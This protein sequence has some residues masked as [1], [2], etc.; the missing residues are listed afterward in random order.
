MFKAQ[1][2]RLLSFLRDL[3]LAT[4]WCA[5]PLALVRYGLRPLLD[6]G[7]VEHPVLA[8][9][10]GRALISAALIAGYFGFCRWSERRSRVE[11]LAWRSRSILFSAA[12]GAGLMALSIGL[13]WVGGVYTFATRESITFPGDVMALILIAATFEEVTF[14]AI[15]FRLA[16]KQWGTRASLGLTA[17]LFGAM[18][19]GN[20]GAGPLT[21]VSVSLLGV[22]WAGIFALT[23]NLWAASANH[24]AWNLTIFLSGLPLS[25]QVAWQEV[26]PLRAASQSSIWLSGGTFGPE[27]SLLTIAVAAVATGWIV[28]RLGHE[29]QWRAG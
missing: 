5:V 21:W 24:A 1:F 6:A 4:L 26:A 18:H 25:G 8:Q 27:D 17:V 15:L 12:A 13:L 2:F 20:V 28:R 29:R 9:A 11:E 10:A 3:A 14:R 16:E 23:R 7:L 19:L 22:M